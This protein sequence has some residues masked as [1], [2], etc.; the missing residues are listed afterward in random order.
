MKS[1]ITKFEAMV[2][3]ALAVTVVTTFAVLFNALFSI[4]VVA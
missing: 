2:C 4:T 3:S 1:L